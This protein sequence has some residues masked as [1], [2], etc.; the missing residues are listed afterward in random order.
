MLWV[1]EQGVAAGVQGSCVQGLQWMERHGHRPSW[2]PRLYVGLR[3]GITVFRSLTSRQALCC[4]SERTHLLTRCRCD[5]CAA[6]Q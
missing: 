6:P 4:R 2:L 3:P 5:S 1:R